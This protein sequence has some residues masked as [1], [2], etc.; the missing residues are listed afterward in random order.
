MQ[1]LPK[2][3][4]FGLDQISLWPVC[5]EEGG[6]AMF[7]TGV[8]TPD[9][10]AAWR[11]LFG[12]S[13]ALAGCRLTR[14]FVTHIHPD[15][16]DMARCLTRKFDCLLWMTRLEYLT[17]RVLVANTDREASADGTEFYRSAG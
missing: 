10:T 3:L 14:V 8:Q 12:A 16:V 6:C 1:W 9:M 17:R 11:K 15:H 4:P 13:A 7:D 2:P 5:D